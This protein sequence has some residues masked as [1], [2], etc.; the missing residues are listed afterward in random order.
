MLR[1]FLF[2]YRKS[3]RYSW[4]KAIDGGATVYVKI[5]PKF[6]GDSFRPD[7]FE[8]EQTIDGITQSFSLDNIKGAKT[9]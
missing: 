1:P 2:V 6:S 3:H 5:K 7:S 9:R 8:I 4:A